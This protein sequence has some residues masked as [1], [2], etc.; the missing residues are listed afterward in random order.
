MSF[1]FAVGGISHETNTYCKE[2]TPIMDF[3]VLRGGQILDVFRGVRFYIGGMI[4]AASELGAE[5]VPTYFAQATPS[6]TIA[7]DAYT[8]MLGQLLAGIR[9]AMPVDGVALAL[10]GAG[11]VDGIH[12]LEGHLCRAVREV[13]GPQAK[14]VVTLDLH[15]NLT[16]DMADVIDMCLASTTTRT[17]TVTSAELRPCT[18]WPLC[19]RVSGNHSSTS[20]GSPPF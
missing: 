4:D 1:R 6:G 16:Q 14:I 3:K 8:S 7:H 20:K 17:R 19:W 18:R 9:E 13:V 11:V 2:Q 5:L 10:H 12:D 15:G